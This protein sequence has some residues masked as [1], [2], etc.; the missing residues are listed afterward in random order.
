MVEYIKT[1][2]AA[3]G[4]GV[5]FAFGGWDTIV[6]VLLAFMALDYIT[7]VVKAIKAKTLS[8]K[9][10][11]NGLFKKCAILVVVVVAVLLDHQINN[12]SFIFRDI[13]CYFYIANEGISILENTVDIGVKVPRKLV[14]ILDR[15]DKDSDITTESQT[16]EKGEDE[17]GKED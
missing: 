7:G 3:I 6:Y 5:A 13:V 14:E 16:T 9:I 4:A 17:N 10:G 15:F 12:G 1:A 11:L 8:S 2:F